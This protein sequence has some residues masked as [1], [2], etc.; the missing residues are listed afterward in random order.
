MSDNAPFVIPSET[1]LSS[2][3]LTVSNMERALDF[4]TSNLG[5]VLHN[6]DRG[7][8]FLG[9]LD[10]V[11]LH[12]I[13]LPEAV[14]PYR[15][16]GLYHFAI[17]LPDRVALA[18]SL[19]NLIEQGQNIQGA[20]DHLVSETLYLA[21]PDGN[22]IELYRDRKRSDWRRINGQLQMAVDPL[23]LDRLLSDTGPGQTATYQVP[24][25][26]RLGH[27]H[28]HVS[29]LQTADFFTV[30]AWDLRKH[31]KC[32]ARQFSMRP[33]DTTITWRGTSGTG[34]ALHPRR[35]MPLECAG[36]PSNCPA[37]LSWNSSRD[38]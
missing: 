15:H 28:L 10:Q 6:H 23:D 2:I 29:N 17:L 27:V 9:S 4:Y 25:E 1:T 31:S 19:R 34:A 30:R 12:L 11:F 26:T 5:L 37:S 14:K 38:T 18:A 13:E 8:A 35:T 20:S 36:L 32:Q 3:D 22:G 24:D 16:S 33:V 21:D 7:N